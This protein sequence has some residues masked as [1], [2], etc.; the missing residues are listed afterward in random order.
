MN[1]QIKFSEQEVKVVNFLIA[2]NNGDVNW[3]DLAKF[4]KDPANIKKKSLQKI[5]SE[6]KRKY[7]SSG[8]TVP[9]NVRFVDGTVA[10]KPK[11]TTQN[12]VQ[13]KKTPGGNTVVVNAV[14]TPAAH[15]DFVLDKAL[16]R[17]KTKYGHQTLNDNEWE[18]FK[19]IHANVGKL[20][21]ISEL[22]DKVVYPQYGSKLPA[23]WFDAIMRII[24]NLRRAVPG[25]NQRLLTVKGAETSYLFQ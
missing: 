24:N 12:I 22:R 16:K 6:I 5:I 10:E 23:R 9:F 15:V 1:A 3:N 11:D 2:N 20:I 18:V 13:V 8:L 7:A 14:N 19:Y 17:V 4:T 25:L 21:P